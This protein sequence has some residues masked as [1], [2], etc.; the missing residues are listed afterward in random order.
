MITTAMHDQSA[1]TEALRADVTARIQ[2]D[3]AAA[4]AAREDLRSSSEVMK[5]QLGQVSAVL[6]YDILQQHHLLS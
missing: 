5:Q 4:L 1:A 3:A 6:S 2:D